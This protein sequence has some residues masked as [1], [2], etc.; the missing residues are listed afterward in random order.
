[1]LSIATSLASPAL[2]HFVL[3]RLPSGSLHR[4]ERRYSID[5]MRNTDLKTVPDDGSTIV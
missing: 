3:G 2:S 1:M 5:I 4:Q